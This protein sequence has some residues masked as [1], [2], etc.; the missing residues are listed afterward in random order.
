MRI[1]TS[2]SPAVT[3]RLRHLVAAAGLA[4][5]ATSTLAADRG[6]DGEFDQRSS[7]H[8]VLRQ[9]VDIDRRTGPQGTTDFE[10][11]ILAIL[12]QAY[13]LVD[14]TLGLRPRR[15]I[16][17][18]VYDPAVFDAEF[19]GVFR[20]PAAGFYHGVIRVR[21]DSAVTRELERVLHHEL[22]HAALDE[23]APSHPPPAWLNEGLAEWVE[24]RAVGKRRLNPAEQATLAQAGRANALLP[25][26]ALSSPS[27][28]HLGPDAAGLAYLQSYALVDHLVDVRGERVLRQVVRRWIRTGDVDRTLE[29]SA[30]MDVAELERSF[31]ASLGISG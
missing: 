6:A 8:F 19:N 17:V 21:G 25:L 10:R 27:L 13:D 14:D 31:E 4:S 12:E 30:G 5:L 29:G 15:R 18:V 11:R 22:V 9:D 28:S 1:A 24:A 3:R 20:F 2:G 16:E 23:A 7:T 26:T